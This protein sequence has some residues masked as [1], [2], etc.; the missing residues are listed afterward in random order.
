MAFPRAW[1]GLE[2]VFSGSERKTTETSVVI[3]IRALRRRDEF[4]AG[5]SS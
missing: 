1:M 2:I 3:E 4:S 5:V